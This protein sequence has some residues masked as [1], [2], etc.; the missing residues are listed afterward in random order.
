MLE[1]QESGPSFSAS[2]LALRPLQLA[3]LLR[4]FKLQTS[5]R[6]LCLSGT[7]LGDDS[8]QELLASIR[9]MPGLR[10]LDLS[11][12]RLGPEGLR[13]L[14]AGPSGAPTFQVGPE[15]E[16]RAGR[17]EWCF[18]CLCLG[19]GDLIRGRGGGLVGALGRQ[20]LAFHRTSHIF[21]SCFCFT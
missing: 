21:L 16:P 3:P 19:F 6:Q 4:A 7:G 14:G 9:T 10:R 20:C 8:A 1:R 11:G 5:I 12:N 15:G 13:K 2:G 17:Q 18:A